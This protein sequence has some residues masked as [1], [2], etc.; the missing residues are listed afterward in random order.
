MKKLLLLIAVL[1]LT[2][3]KDEKLAAIPEGIRDFELTTGE[4]N[5]D[6]SLPYDVVIYG[7]TVAGISAACELKNSGFSVLLIHP[8]GTALGGMTTNGLGIS[9]VHNTSVLGGLTRKFYQDIKKYYSNPSNWFIDG[10]HEYARFSYNGDVMLWFEP[11]AARSIIMDYIQNY[12]IPILQNERL[13]LKGGVK[14]DSKKAISEIRMESGLIIKG[15]I[16]IDATYEGDLMAKA[17]VNYTIGREANAQYGETG[18]G[19]QVIHAKDRN[20]LPDGIKLTNTLYKELQLTHGAG[21]KKI[22]AYC[23]RMCLTNYEPNRVAVEKPLKYNESEYEL[24][25]EYIKRYSGNTFFDLMPLPNRKTDSNN[26]GAV[27]TDYVG[28][29]YNYPDGNYQERAEIIEAHK[30]YQIGLLWTLANHPNVPENIRAFYK[31]WGLAKDEFLSNNNWPRQLYIR[32]GRRMIGNYIMTEHN[33]VGKRIS[34]RSIGLGEYPMD[35]HIVQRY[36]DKNGYLKNE[37]Q[38]MMGVPRPYGIDYGSI[39]PKPEECTNLFV[40][41]CLSSSHIAYGSMR[42]E[43]V[44]MNLGQVAGV[45]SAIAIKEKKPVQEVNYELLKQELIK[46]NMVL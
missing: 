7:S 11:R 46:R 21:D 39:V 9:D 27:S 17:G 5:I 10:P 23:F 28:K 3:C 24:L 26:F 29:N 41:V 15:K 42:M 13:D 33:C 45:A 18:N 31:S 35:S 40:L 36:I 32:E 37:G 43:P 1:L 4:N 8:V 25:F 44:F 38:T 12:K 2:S 6:L 19:M 34:N 20:Q 22:Q 16:F 30:T 14:K